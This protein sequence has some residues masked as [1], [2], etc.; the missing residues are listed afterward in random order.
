MQDAKPSPL[1]FGSAS[2]DALSADAVATSRLRI[3]RNFHP[4]DTHPAHRFLNAVEPGSYIR[5]HRHADPLKDETFVALRGAFGVVLF[6]DS[7]NVTA[8]AVIGPAGDPVGAHIPAGV[9]HALVALEPGSVFFE[10]KAGPYDVRTDKEWGGWA[11]P[12]DDPAAASYLA[13]LRALF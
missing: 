9:F 8:Q 4:D 5:P 2:F 6:D 13:K 11:P 12:E 3:N 10:V 7:G 1:F